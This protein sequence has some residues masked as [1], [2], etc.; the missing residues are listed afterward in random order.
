MK[1]SSVEKAKVESTKNPNWLELPI[2]L[3][4]NIL[5][6]LDTVDIVTTARSVCPL[7]RNICKDPLMWCTIHISNINVIPLDYHYLHKIY[8]HAIDLSCGHVEAFIL[9]Y[10]GLMT[11]SNIRLLGN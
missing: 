8:G 6:R 10:L 4:R 3:I 2:D 11:F 7:W 1:G 5:Q 9:S